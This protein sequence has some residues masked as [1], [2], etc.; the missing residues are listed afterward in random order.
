MRILADTL[1]LDRLYPFPDRLVPFEGNHDVSRLMTEAKGDARRVKL[2][3]AILFTLRGTPQ[4]YY[5]DEIAMEGNGDPDNRR[6]FPGGFPGD[7]GNAF[8]EAG[9]TPE[10]QDIFHYVRFLLHLRTAHPAL[11]TGTLKDILVDDSAYVYSREEGSERIL[12]AIN[13][14]DQSRSIKLP[15]FFSGTLQPLSEAA[16]AAA[17]TE[18]GSQIELPG[19]TAAIYLV[20]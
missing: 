19:R 14:A 17:L 8:T 2:A 15:G 6:D 5:G 18:S 11:R 16:P 7:M 9:R 20:R 10:Q 3:F 13:S 1:R 12:V 4:M